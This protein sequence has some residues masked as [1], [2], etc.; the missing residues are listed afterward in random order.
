MHSRRN[1]YFSTG[2]EFVREKISNQDF[3]KKCSSRHSS[4]SAVF[5][6][7]NKSNQQQCIMSPAAIHTDPLMKYQVLSSVI[8]ESRNF[9]VEDSKSY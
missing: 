4:V 5:L 2:S 1:D 7:L 6:V 9:C 8:L 3:S